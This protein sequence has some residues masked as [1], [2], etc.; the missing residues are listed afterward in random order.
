MHGSGKLAAADQGIDLGLAQLHQS[1]DFLELQKAA[2]KLTLASA[3]IERCVDFH[4]DE[5]AK[6]VGG[7]RGDCWPV[8]PIN[9]PVF[10]IAAE[11]WISISTGCSSPQTVFRAGERIH[12]DGTVPTAQAA[13]GILRALG[14]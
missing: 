5:N 8:L 10:P 11:N 4:A 3:S 1:A 9:R 7:N 12:C 14:Q 2:A 13:F 6:F